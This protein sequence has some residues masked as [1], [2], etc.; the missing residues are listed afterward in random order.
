MLRPTNKAG[1]MASSLLVSTEDGHHRPL[2]TLPGTRASAE[3]PLVAATAPG[4]AER[5]ALPAEERPVVTASNPVPQPAYD[6]YLLH[7]HHH[8]LLYN[9]YNVCFTYKNQ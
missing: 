7:G 6:D 5:A 1:V 9:I 8:N 2:P 3:T 4:T